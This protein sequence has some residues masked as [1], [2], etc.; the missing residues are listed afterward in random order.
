MRKLLFICLMIGGVAQAQTD[1]VIYYADSLVYR[2][3]ATIIAGSD[4]I[5]SDSNYVRHNY[6]FIAADSTYEDQFVI[7]DSLGRVL[8]PIQALID[9]GYC[10]SGTVNKKKLDA[11]QIGWTIEQLRDS[12]I[13]PDLRSIYGTSNVIKL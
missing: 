7:I 5:T 12:L 3:D 10:S 11:T 13:L 9:S 1:S 6:H 2:I 4:T 8:A